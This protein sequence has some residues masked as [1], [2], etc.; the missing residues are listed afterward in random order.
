VEVGCR[1]DRKSMTSELNVVKLRD[2]R[3]GDN[4]SLHLQEKRASQ[5]KK[6]KKQTPMIGIGF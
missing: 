1:F 4:L 3:F 5:A 6:Q 2:G